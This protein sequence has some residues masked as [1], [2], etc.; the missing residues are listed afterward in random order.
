MTRFSNFGLESVNVSVLPSNNSK[1]VRISC[2]PVVVTPRFMPYLLTEVRNQVEAIDT[3]ST[4]FLNGFVRKNKQWINKILLKYG[5]VLFRG[6]KVESCFEFE[7]I[8]LSYDDKT[9][10]NEYLGTSP[11]NVMPGT[12]Y[13]FSAAEVPVNYPNAQHLEMS[14]L[15]SPPAHV[16]FGCMKEPQ[17]IGGETSLCD[18]RKVYQD[19]P[20]EL[21]M[22]F[23]DLGVMYS[24]TQSRHG[25][26]GLNYD[27]ADMKGWEDVFG[28][29]DK[30]EVEKIWKKATSATTTAR[31][32]T[33]A[34]YTTTTPGDHTSNTSPSNDTSSSTRVVILRTAL[35][36]NGRGIL[37][38]VRLE[39]KHVN[40][41]L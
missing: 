22:K 2:T 16:F 37:L 14:F 20:Y 5:A 4:K 24:R 31:I 39:P 35:H 41:T 7:Q 8:L 12:N 26:P 10:C 13:I 36:L 30:N 1:S 17:S 6:F 40:S 23:I 32:T 19:I 34:R 27:V 21:L 3:T 25:N 11:R 28:T 38:F 33:P 18:F 29:S 15:P 9:L